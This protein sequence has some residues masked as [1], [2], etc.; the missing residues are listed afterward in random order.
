MRSY[1]TICIV[2]FFL[3]LVNDTFQPTNFA[4]IAQYRKPET[5]TRSYPLNR[6]AINIGGADGS[7]LGGFIAARHYETLFLVAGF[8]NCTPWLGALRKSS[9][10]P[11]AHPSPTAGGLETCGGG[12]RACAYWPPSVT[13]LLPKKKDTRA[14]PRAPNR[15]LPMRTI[16]LPSSTATR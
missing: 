9:G 10:Q 6:L 1:A 15:A 16:V 2:T 5:R 7:S 11:Q 14:Y 12:L 13:T 4:A 3:S 8:T